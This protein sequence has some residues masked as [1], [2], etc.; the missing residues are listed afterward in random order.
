MVRLPGD[1]KQTYQFISRP[2]MWPS[3]STLAMTLTLNFQGQIYNLFYLC[4]KW[5]DCHETKSKHIDW[6]LNLK[7]SCHIWPLPA[8]HWIC[9]AKY[10]IIYISTKVVGLPRNEKQ[11]YRSNSKP[12]VWPMGLTLAMTMAF[13]F[14][15]S[16][17]ILT[18]WWSRSGVRIYHVVTRVTSDVG[19][20]STH[21][22]IY[23]GCFIS[24]T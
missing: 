9:K 21:L 10:G 2:Q 12:Q 1:E 20:S 16:N 19:V 23:Y 6:T 5:S 17:V 4:Q 11:I 8:W 15:R 18:I 22:V 3:V 14:S 24:I 13:Y 7:C